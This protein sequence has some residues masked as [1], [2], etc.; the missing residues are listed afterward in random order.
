MISPLLNILTPI[1]ICAAIGIGWKKMGFDY[2]SEFIG[3][4]VMNI[5]A[6]CLILHSL[7][8]TKV[9]LSALGDVALVA[10]LILG[11]ML[12]CCFVVLKIFNLNY[13]TYLPPLLFPNSGNMGLPLCLFAFGE[14]GLTLAIGYFLLMMFGHLTLGLLILEGIEDGLS[15]ALKN[16]LKQ[17]MVYAMAIGL[18]L[19]GNQIALPVWAAHTV[20]LLSGVTIP[21]MLIT[22]GV[23]LTSLKVEFWQRALS[24]SLF[25]LALSLLVAASACTLL[26]LEGVT[27]NVILLQAAMPAAVFN[28]LF[29][30][31]Y[32][33]KPE[34]VAGIVVVSTLTTVLVLPFLLSYLIL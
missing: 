32:Q 34:E 13:K 11:V 22:L 9:S 17:P 21:L 31:H 7:V 14:T 26:G 16:L 8:G 20:E 29:A 5:G 25:K 12:V 1:V 18:I 10:T 3:R 33:Q 2:P 28:Y 30:V 27:R 4:L 24:L 6:P 15:H 19:C 23:S